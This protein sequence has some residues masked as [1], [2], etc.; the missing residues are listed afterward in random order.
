M[1]SP[2][3]I[4]ALAAAAIG[5]AIYFVGGAADQ[6]RPTS[7]P[8]ADTAAHADSA[9]PASGAQGDSGASAVAPSQRPGEAARAVPDDPRLAALMVSP[10]N[11]FIEFVV[12]AN[13]KVVKEID[14]DPS[15][16]SFKR[17]L[18][19]YTYSDGKVIGLTAYHYTG[20]QIQ[21][22]TTAVAYKPDG[23]IDNYLQSTSYAQEQKPPQR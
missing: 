15:S 3:L 7:P 6:T 10:D 14:K 17:P 11:G 16:L 5:V 12:D 22:T 4:G 13:G 19:E 1:R 8:A 21:V 2:I 18:R 23:S 20:D 9:T